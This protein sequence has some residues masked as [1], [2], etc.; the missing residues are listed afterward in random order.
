MRKFAFLTTIYPID[1]RYITDFFH[2]LINQTDT[3]FDLIILNDDYLEFSALKKQYSGLSIIELKSANNIALNRERLIKYAI[4]NNYCFA[5]FG[6][7]DDYFESNRVQVSKSLLEASDI[8][9]N[10]LTSFSSVGVINEKILSSRIV[11]NSVITLDFILEKNIFGLSNTAI[12]LDGLQSQDIMFSPDIV[13][14]DWYF[15]STLLLQ[16]RRAV[17]T[18]DTV[19]YYRQHDSNTVGIGSVTQESINNAIVVK[20]RHYFY[21][22]DKSD[23]YKELLEKNERLSSLILTEEYKLKLIAKNYKTLQNPLWWELIYLG[24]NDEIDE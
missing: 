12:K 11:N 20:Q 3:D 15:F 9:V 16:G 18:S 24:I 2:S 5:L 1:E 7:I 4:D 10:D 19:T 6:D 13:A 17:F 14:V 21:M 8:V 23:V 22:N